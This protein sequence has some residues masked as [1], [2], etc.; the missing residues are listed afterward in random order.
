MLKLDFYFLQFLLKIQ[1][2]EKS[3]KDLNSGEEPK[4]INYAICFLL[5]CIIVK[6]FYENC[7]N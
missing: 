2:C 4:L 6:I 5:Y 3:V 7:Q 1:S